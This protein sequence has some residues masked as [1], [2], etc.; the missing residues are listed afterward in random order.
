MI[1][2]RAKSSFQTLHAFNDRNTHF[3]SDVH[4]CLEEKLDLALSQ[5]MNFRWISSLSLFPNH[6]FFCSLLLCLETFPNHLDFFCGAPFDRISPL[7]F[8]DVSIS[9]LDFHVSF[10]VCPCV[11][12]W[13]GFLSLS[14]QFMELLCQHRVSRG[15]KQATPLFN[16]WRN[17]DFPCPT[18]CPINERPGEAHPFPFPARALSRARNAHAARERIQATPP[19]H[20]S[21][22]LL[23]VATLQTQLIKKFQRT[24]LKLG[25]GFCGGF[26]SCEI[27]F[28]AR[29]DIFANVLRRRRRRRSV[30]TFSFSFLSITYFLLNRFC[31][32]FHHRLQ[33]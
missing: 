18:A 3:C 27:R 28:S 10:D 14:T 24:K 15:R 32:F 33:S 23:G 30:S 8:M 16:E 9:L 11:S 19:F 12:F 4:V 5:I 31:L 25:H 6:H 29:A 7:F 1:W 21:C 17:I 13:Q 22:R 26:S 2:E 20:V